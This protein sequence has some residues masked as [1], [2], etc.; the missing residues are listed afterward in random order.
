MKY[1]NTPIE[2][3]KKISTDFVGRI[4]KPKNVALLQTRMQYFGRSISYKK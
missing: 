3:K 2:T 4:F 1:H